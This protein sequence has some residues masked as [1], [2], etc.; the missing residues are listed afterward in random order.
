MGATNIR[1]I[2]NN[3]YRVTMPHRWFRNEAPERIVFAAEVVG[4]EIVS[5]T[6]CG[7]NFWGCGVY[8][9]VVK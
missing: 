5:V 1:K 3:H 4:K 6:H 9:L 2:D 7:T 8:L